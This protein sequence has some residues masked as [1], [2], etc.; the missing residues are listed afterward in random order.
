MTQKVRRSLALLLGITLSTL[1]VA[2]LEPDQDIPAEPVIDVT[3]EVEAAVVKGADLIGRIDFEA[4]HGAGILLNLEQAQD[5]ERLREIAEA[6]R[7]FEEATGLTREDLRFIV[8]SANTTTLDTRASREMRLEAM[9]AV[10]GIALAKPLTTEQLAQGI[11]AMAPEG[12][13][14]QVREMEIAGRTALVI[15]PQTP[16]QNAAYVALSPESTTVFLSLSQASL[17]AA[18]T[19]ADRGEIEVASPSL[20]SAQTVLPVDS[21]FRLAFVVPNALRS[22]LRQAID[23]A[24]ENPQMAM[25]A[26]FLESFQDLQS[27]ALGVGLSQEMALDL[28]CDLGKDESA[29][30]AATLIKAFLAPMMKAALESSEQPS[31]IADSLDVSPEGS[32]LKLGLRLTAEDLESIGTNAENVAA[33][34]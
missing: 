30:Q 3:P 22:K 25:L 33:G 23:G 21:Q 26:G 4:M 24:G 19:R 17:A 11:Q 28:V 6:N 5:N 18:L 15:E 10:M 29:Q 27:L 8:F 1:L 32:S 13:Q 12:P 34:R 14:P 16:Q 31:H 20:I 9:D 7:R 2:C